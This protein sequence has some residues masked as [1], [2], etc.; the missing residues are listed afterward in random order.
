MSIENGA[1]VRRLYEE[2]WNKQEFELVDE[3]ISP[4]HGLQAPNLSPPRR[5]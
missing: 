5:V 1:L 4:S 3:L 2:V